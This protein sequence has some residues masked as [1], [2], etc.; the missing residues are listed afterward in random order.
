[1]RNFE[2]K[3]I[4]A[5]LEGRKEAET[6]VSPAVVSGISLCFGRHELMWLCGCS[7]E[8]FPVCCYRQ[9]LLL[10]KVSLYFCKTDFLKS[11]TEIKS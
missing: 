2:K 1:M 5:S 10:S 3:K 4:K 8:N 6:T 11:K 7:P 9:F